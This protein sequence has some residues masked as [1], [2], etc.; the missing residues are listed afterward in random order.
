MK[1]NALIGQSGGPTSVIN[2]SLYGAISTALSSPRID[3]VFGMRYGVEGFM[4]HEIVDLGKEDRSRLELLMKTPSS[5]LGSCRYK[6]IEDDLPKVFSLLE[7][8]NIRFLFMIGGN[9]TM[10]TIH[11]IEAYAASRG[12]E[13][14]G[15]GIPKT[16]DNDLFGTDHTPGY[17]SAARYTTLSVT[18]AGL[19][20]CD[21]QRVDRFVVHQTV[22]RD[23]GWLAASSALAR[24]REGGA[25]HIILLPERPI[26]RDVLLDSVKTAADTHG[27]AYVVVGEGALWDNGNPISSSATTDN[28]SNVE[29]GA[30]GGS[31]AA[32]NLHGLITAETGFR[33][34]FQITESLSMCADDRVSE[35]DRI[36]A[37]RCG[38]EAVELALSGNSGVMVTIERASDKPY[39]T[40]LGTVPLGDVARQTKPMPDEFIS[41]SGMDVTTEFLDYLQPLIGPRPE[42]AAL[43]YIRANI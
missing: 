6:L 21:M 38:E 31:S 29:F 32:L 11:R 40:K 8:L 10:D 23:A 36:E 20:S 28:F 14:S 37:F 34:E 1:G 19:L 42:Y 17:P 22:G 16:V 15:V 12:Y 2:A 18:Q 9:D 25:P 24:D 35:I 7:K 4:N 26:S 39:E 43:A 3:K 30:M 5:A 33:G 13:L 41:E 27:F